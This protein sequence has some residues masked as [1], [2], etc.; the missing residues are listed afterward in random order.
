LPETTTKATKTR[1][2]EEAVSYAIGH[3]T[4]IEILA[5]LNEGT[6]SPDEL[7]RRLQ[8]PLSRVTHHIKELLDAR[9]IEIARV[10]K[11]RNVSQNF[12]RAVEVPFLSDEDLAAKTPEER[13]EFYGLILQASMAEALAAFWAGKITNDPRVWLAWCYFNVDVQGREE[14][15]DELAESWARMIEIE[16]RAT[17]RR[18][19]SGEP[20]ITMIVTTYGHERSR[21]MASSLRTRK[22]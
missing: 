19:E 22:N 8:Q 11:I 15:A 4:R 9:S 2:V 21:S 1:S 5:T 10:D 20:P 13:H 7:A 16:A 14:I 18:A 6:Y 12:Y 17:S 3:R